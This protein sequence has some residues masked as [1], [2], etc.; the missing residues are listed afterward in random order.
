MFRQYIL[1]KILLKE[2]ADLKHP[3]GFYRFMLKCLN[4]F[5]CQIP[6]DE[7]ERIIIQILDARM[8]SGFP[9]AINCPWKTTETLAHLRLNSI[10]S[11]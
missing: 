10:L 3:A 11:F 2:S 4:G 9:R 6:T 1:D 8:S 5:W 7:Q